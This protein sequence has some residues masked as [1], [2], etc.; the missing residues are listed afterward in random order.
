ML[1]IALMAISSQKSLAENS[2]VG[3][4]TIAGIDFLDS[5]VFDIAQANYSAG[6]VSF[7][8][9]IHSND[10]VNAL[11]F[12][13]KF[14]QNNFVYDSIINLSAN[15]Q[16]V[17]YFNLAD[18]TIR[19][20]SYSLQPIS[21]DTPLV[22]IQFQVLSG[23]FCVA[24]ISQLTVLLNGDPCTGKVSDCVT[25]KVGEISTGSVFEVYP[26]P[27]TDL[28]TIETVSCES[29]EILNV[30]G[31]QVWSHDGSFDGKLSIDLSQLKRGIYIVQAIGES[32]KQSQRIILN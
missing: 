17:S 24:D 32:G 25:N 19:F 30:L 10:T 1:A 18:S 2:G 31:E 27:V 28:L 5:V 26:N 21:I 22:T 7:P 9:Y 15:L 20:S 8:I 29:I 6:L 14:N 12:S 3:E 4:N 23:T 13:L 11:D 16:G